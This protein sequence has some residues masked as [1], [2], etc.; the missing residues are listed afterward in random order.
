MNPQ[1][2]KPDSLVQVVGHEPVVIGILLE[3]VG[4]SVTRTTGQ[5]KGVTSESGFSFSSRRFLAA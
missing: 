1:K 3:T 5:P 4:Y 2:S